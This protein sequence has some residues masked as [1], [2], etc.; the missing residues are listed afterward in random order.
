LS[1]QFNYSDVSKQ[2]QQQQQQQSVNAV[3][4]GAVFTNVGP[5]PIQIWG[6]GRGPSFLSVSLIGAW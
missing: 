3:D 5:G 6:R 1:K 2:Q 4:I